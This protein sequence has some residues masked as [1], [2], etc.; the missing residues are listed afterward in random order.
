MSEKRYMRY[1][2]GNFTPSEMVTDTN[3]YI[4]CVELVL[5]F[6]GVVE[7]LVLI[8]AILTTSCLHLNLRI[9][10]CNCCIGFIMTAI[11]RSMI[12]IPLCIAHLENVDVSS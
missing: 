5:L 8:T 9:L 4:Y 11:G 3:F 6:I 12:A 10:I 7:N 1:T 2:H